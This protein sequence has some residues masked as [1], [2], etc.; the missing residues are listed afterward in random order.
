MVYPGKQIGS[1]Q[2]FTCH[3]ISQIPELHSAYAPDAKCII[4]SFMLHELFY[5]KTCCYYCIVALKWVDKSH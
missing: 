1:V 4:R 5:K 3:D 2:A